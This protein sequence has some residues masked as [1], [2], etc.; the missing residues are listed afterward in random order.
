MLCQDLWHSLGLLIQLLGGL[1]PGGVSLDLLIDFLIVGFDIL[2]P[3]HY[4]NN[5]VWTGGGAD[6]PTLLFSAE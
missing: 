3:S 2:E 4:G 6:L 5:P 1:V